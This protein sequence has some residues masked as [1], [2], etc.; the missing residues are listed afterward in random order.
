LRIC[1]RQIAY[2][3]HQLT[4]VGADLDALGP[5]GDGVRVVEELG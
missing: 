5:D 1:G 4:R 3:V 2:M